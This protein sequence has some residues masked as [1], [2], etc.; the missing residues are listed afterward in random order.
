M[1]KNLQ[2]RMGR[3]SVPEEK[4]ISSLMRRNDF[5]NEM[6]NFEKN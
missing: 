1:N 5:S 6:I 4:G 3:V 2:L